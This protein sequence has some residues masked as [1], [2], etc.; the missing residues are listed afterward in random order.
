[1]AEEPIVKE[2]YRMLGLTLIFQMGQT[3]PELTRIMASLLEAWRTKTIP[4]L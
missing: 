1:L 4:I 2:V 3:Q